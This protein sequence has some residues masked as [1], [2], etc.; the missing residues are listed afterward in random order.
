MSH[1]TE[2]MA[3]F[4]TSDVVRNKTVAKDHAAKA[5]PHLTPT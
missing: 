4:R 5:M 1:W 3:R 2:Y